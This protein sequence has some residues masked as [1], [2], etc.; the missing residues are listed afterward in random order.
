M[1]ARSAT[2]QAS[3]GPHASALL[4]LQ[5]IKHNQ[6]YTAVPTSYSLAHSQLAARIES[7]RMVWNISHRSI[8]MCSSKNASMVWM[9]RCDVGLDCSSEGFHVK[10]TTQMSTPHNPAPKAVESQDSMPA[11][12]KARFPLWAGRRS[13]R[14]AA[15]NERSSLLRCCAVCI[16]NRAPY[17][18]PQHAFTR[19][20]AP[21][22][23][24]VDCCNAD[25]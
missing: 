6:H 1:N 21:C 25:V 5:Y 10:Q 15:C 22:Y 17:V 16:Q 11:Q 4:L 23:R 7:R 19:R 13:K 8:C 24:L 3:G 9:E 20:R 12:Q 2:G 18:R 14:P